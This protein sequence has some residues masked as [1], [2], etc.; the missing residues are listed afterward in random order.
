[1]L[2]LH[3]L[4]KEMLELPVMLGCPPNRRVV[5]DWKSAKESLSKHQIIEMPFDCRKPDPA[6]PCFYYGNGILSQSTVRYMYMY[7]YMYTC[8]N[9]RF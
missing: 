8:M 9:A 1:M 3:I 6:M 4:F 2:S 7:M 5:F